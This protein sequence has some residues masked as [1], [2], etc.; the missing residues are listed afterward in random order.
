[1]TDDA[2]SF[3]N[4]GMK[5][6]PLFPLDAHFPLMAPLLALSWAL[7]ASPPA[8]AQDNVTKTTTAENEDVD[9][10]E[11]RDLERFG[12][13]FD[14]QI[15]Q[16]KTD[17]A[18]RKKM[19]RD[20][21]KERETATHK[22]QIFMNAWKKL[23]AIATVDDV[24]VL[25][26][27]KNNL[28]TI[29]GLPGNLVGALARLYKNE[30]RLAMREQI[31]KTLRDTPSSEAQRVMLELGIFDPTANKDSINFRGDLEIVKLGDLAEVYCDQVPEKIRKQFETE[32][33]CSAKYGFS[34]R[35]QAWVILRTDENNDDVEDLTYLSA[36]RQKKFRP[37]S[38]SNVLKCLNGR[39]SQGLQ[40][41]TDV[42]ENY[43]ILGTQYRFSKIAPL[44]RDD[45][46]P[47]V[48]KAPKKLAVR[49]AEEIR[50]RS[51]GYRSAA[52]SSTLHWGL[53]GNMV[54]AI[55]EP[56]SE[57]MIVLYQAGSEIYKQIFDSA[58][59]GQ[60]EAVQVMDINK[61]GLPEILI[62]ETVNG[63]LVSSRLYQFR[64]RR[65]VELGAGDLPKPKPTPTPEQDQTAPPPTGVS[66]N[67]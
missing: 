41:E 18:L 5:L 43:K 7:L 38:F 40:S 11:K 46:W 2:D 49:I 51:R 17:K 42:F 12:K 53:P 64:G 33:G 28:C 8:H 37:R 36:D 34:E 19:L 48:R 50:S 20:Y 61:N 60:L 21:L 56:E 52:E 25:L 3:Q 39:Q 13:S 27:Y 44:T 66:P 6:R 47:R 32:D 45:V 29:Q 62:R 4:R 54:V 57:R 15:A 26:E 16:A 1:M 63:Q 58:E 35:N 59:S 65:F 55:P 23:E 31:A 30:Q 24:G 22:T 67:P 10:R 9:P 14:N